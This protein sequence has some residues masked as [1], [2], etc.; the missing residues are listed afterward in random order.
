M[1]HETDTYTAE[2]PGLPLL[3]AK[4]ARTNVE[5]RMERKGY[6]GPRERQRCENCGACGIT[7]LNPDGLNER[8]VLRCKDG[9]FPVQ[10]GG[11]CPD[12]RVA[13]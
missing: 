6:R 5:M 9:D 11:I 2:L 4:Q 12:W 7:V 8:E 1:R 10:R 13:R 3:P